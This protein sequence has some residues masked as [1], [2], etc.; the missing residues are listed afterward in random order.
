LCRSLRFWGS[1]QP[2]ERGCQGISNI[3]DIT[4]VDVAGGSGHF[5]QMEILYLLT[6]H[7]Q[8]DARVGQDSIAVLM[9]CLPE[10]E[11][12]GDFRIVW[13]PWL[14]LGQSIPHVIPYYLRKNCE[15]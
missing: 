10:P 4:P 13:M 9:T 8:L 14:P 15:E 11:S 2:F 1:A 3:W 7:I 6:Y 12:P 5:L